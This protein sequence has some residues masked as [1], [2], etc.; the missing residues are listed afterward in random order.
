[1]PSSPPPVQQGPYRRAREAL[2][3]LEPGLPA[4]W[5]RDA[6]HHERELQAI[7]YR[8][9]VCV[10]REEEI[11]APRDYKAV[12]V[13]TQPVL[14]LRHAD[15]GLRAFHNVC[16]HRG[17]VL[18]TEAAGK[19]SSER[20]V[21]PYHAWTYD[22]DGRLAAT[23]RQMDT[24]GFD[25]SRYPLHDVAVDAWGGFIFVN[26]L[27][28]SAPPLMD[29][30]ADIPAQFERHDFAGL[31]IGKRI[32]LDVQANWKL[33]LE[34]FS[35]CYHCPVVHPEFCELVPAYRA[36]G[37]WGLAGAGGPGGAHAPEYKAGARTLTLD[38]SARL[39]PFAGLS[40]EDRDTL[41]VA[42]S[43]PPGMLL[44]VHP[45]Y[46]NAQTVFPT[47]PESVRIVYD[48]LF[49][50]RHMPMP[51]ADLHHYVALWDL[52]NRQDARN[53]EWQQRG[54]ASQA[55][56]HGYYTPQEFDCHRFARWV[57]GSLGEPA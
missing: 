46:V 33:L 29:A 9:W 34:N 42:Q 23:P 43:F 44:N 32:V 19:L 51:E 38:G 47:G 35:E 7:W 26:L 18:C 13:G 37:Q 11:A 16:R 52:T 14:L 20:I 22:M 28:E 39:P 24:P 48:W 5:Y 50:A 40:A 8:S 55:F 36:A 57:R 15:G 49:E 3:R 56:E 30:L 4:H 54:L 31:R 45:D 10:G 2:S 6:T 25:Q 21:C 17:S 27:G 12:Q 41:Y 53:C 1:M